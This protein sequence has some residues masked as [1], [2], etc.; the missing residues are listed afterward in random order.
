MHR[1]TPQFH[2]HVFTSHSHSQHLRQHLYACSPASDNL[3][4]SISCTVSH[5]D[6]LHHPLVPVVSVEV[7]EMVLNVIC[8]LMSVMAVK[9]T[10]NSVPFLLHLCASCLMYMPSEE[11]HHK[12]VS[13]LCEY[14]LPMT[15]RKCVTSQYIHTYIQTYVHMYICTCWC[16]VHECV[17]PLCGWA[18]VGSVCG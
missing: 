11:A 4:A 10:E 12:I 3:G 7:G 16:Y 15:I 2:L 17:S 1:T 6:L 13:K 5:A 9:D 8:H 18:N 14:I